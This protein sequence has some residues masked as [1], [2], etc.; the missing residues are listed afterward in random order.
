MPQINYKNFYALDRFKFDNTEWCGPG[1]SDGKWQSNRGGYATARSRF[2]QAC[3]EHDIDIANGVPLQEADQRFFAAVP[4]P[5]IGAGPYVAHYLSGAHKRDREE[6]ELHSRKKQLLMPTMDSIIFD[7]GKATTQASNRNIV[8]GSGAGTITKVGERKVAGNRVG[9]RKNTEL[10]F[11]YGGSYKEEVVAGQPI[12]QVL[13]VGHGTYNRQKAATGFWCSIVKKLVEQAGFDVPTL[14][15]NLFETPGSINGYYCDVAYQQ[16]GTSGI[17]N[18]LTSQALDVYTYAQQIADQFESIT[19]TFVLKEIV[20]RKGESSTNYQEDSS[21]NL[22]RLVIHQ[23]V[24]SDV[25]LQNNTVATVTTGNTSTDVLG[26]NPLRYKKYYIKGQMFEILGNTEGDNLVGLAGLGK[27]K[28]TNASIGFFNQNSNLTAKEKQFLREPPPPKNVADCVAVGG[29]CV[30]PGAFLYS[31]CVYKSS[32]YLNTF[33]ET[34]VNPDAIG[35]S[36]AQ[37]DSIGPYGRTEVFAFDKFL[38]TR[39]EQTAPIVAFQI[40]QKVITS[41]SMKRIAPTQPLRFI[42]TEVYV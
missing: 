15:A 10:M 26:S 8:T 29:G 40:K 30:Q 41:L 39:V 19:T 22:E 34:A 24:V 20:W 31:D 1:W 28:K 17:L 12:S 11:E 23:T 42:A 38:D 27:P 36:G 16:V 6:N 2:D 33:Y 25:A 7:T 21:L 13:Y 14:D 32:F 37:N 3:K 35:P 4:N 9:S 5:I 18:F